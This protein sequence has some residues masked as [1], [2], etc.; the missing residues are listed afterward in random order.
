M[1]KHSFIRLFCGCFF[2][3]FLLSSCADSTEFKVKESGEI[4]QVKTKQSY[5][6]TPSCYR[7]YSYNSGDYVGTYTKDGVE[8]KLYKITGDGN[9][10]CDE[11]YNIYLP[12]GEELPTLSKMHISEI[13]LCKPSVQR[14][15]EASYSEKKD[16]AEILDLFDGVGI[17]YD[18]ILEPASEHYDILFLDSFVGLIL[19]R[20][21]LVYENPIV[22]YEPL[23]A[24]GSAPD[25]YGVEPTIEEVSGEEVAVYR[26][27][28]QLILDRDAGDAGV[29]YIAPEL[30]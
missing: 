13:D 11:D 26:L 22:L 1:K 30:L 25:L 2:L 14:Y 19:S 23:N 29:C 12:K 28:T 8:R 7:A 24:D 20:E 27:G 21:Y 10:L 5:I 16:I 18:R 17:P 9:F 15:A 3:L 6:V 4:Y